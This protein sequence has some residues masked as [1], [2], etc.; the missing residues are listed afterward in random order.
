MPTLKQLHINYYL[1]GDPS[2]A[3]KNQLSGI[4]L[5]LPKHNGI[6]NNPNDSFMK[7]DS[8][9]NFETRWP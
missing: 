6:Q 7:T 4:Q 1:I 8:K 2:I 9:Q 5:H 3:L